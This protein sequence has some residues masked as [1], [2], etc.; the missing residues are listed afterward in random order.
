MV[1]DML[2]IDCLEASKWS[3][4]RFLEL[5]EGG[6]DCVHVTLAIWENARE[7]LTRIGHWRRLLDENSDLVALAL[8]ADDIESIT[9]SGRTAVVWGFQNTSPLEDDIDLVETFRWAS[10][11]SS[12]PTTCRT[13]SH[14]A[15]G[16][17]PPTGSRSSTGATSSGR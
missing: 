15:A 7:T 10:A 17:I 16:R 3:R 6:V 4:E 8:A 12:S 13:T 9:A 1:R 5:R 14:P 11:S 2:L